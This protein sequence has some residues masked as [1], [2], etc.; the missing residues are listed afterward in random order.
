MP[1]QPTEGEEVMSAA[2][3]IAETSALQPAPQ[4]YRRITMK[5]GLKLCRQNLHIAT[6]FEAA[7][8]ALLELL[9]KSVTILRVEIEGSHPVIEVE[10]CKAVLG[11]P[12]V[13]RAITIGGARVHRR[14]ASLHGCTIVWISYQGEMQ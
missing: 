5:P 7:N 1:V 9:R 12:N 4:L 10:E 14:S 13:M 2:T 8:T 11:M 3:Q 6:Q